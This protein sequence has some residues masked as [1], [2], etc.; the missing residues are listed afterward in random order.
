[1]TLVSI[2]VCRLPFN[3]F[4]SPQLVTET[5]KRLPLTGSPQGSPKAQRLLTHF[6]AQLKRQKTQ[7]EMLCL[8]SNL[9]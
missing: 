9:C 2:K 6:H 8:I 7:E 3:T 5:R 1:M 4:I